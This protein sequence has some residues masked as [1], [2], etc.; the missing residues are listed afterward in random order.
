MKIVIDTNAII[1]ALIKNS[2]SRKIILDDNFEF[3]TPDFTLLEIEKYKNEIIE[4]AN[5]SLEEFDIL[6]SLIFEN[7][8]ITSKEEYE[9]YLD[10][11]K[12]LIEDVE[13]IVFVALAIDLKA[14][15]IWSDDS[16]FLKQDKIKI[17]RTFEMV[18][19][20]GFS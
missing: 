19:L 13:D 17:F 7:I 10:D 18:E 15:A 5:I 1:S 14:D 3:F 6:F 2:V 11:A 20:A 12:N 9:K 16:H 4:K 8:N